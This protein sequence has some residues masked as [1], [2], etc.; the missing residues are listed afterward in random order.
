MK[1]LPLALALVLLLA[2]CS[3][4]QEGSPE[5]VEKVVSLNVTS[6]SSTRTT[7]K[8]AALSPKERLEELM[9]SKPSFKAEYEVKTVI[10]GESFEGVER[11]AFKDGDSKEET[12]N[13]S[14]YVVKGKVYTCLRE[15]EWSCL[16]VGVANET[17]DEKLPEN[18]TVTKLPSKTYAGLKGECFKVEGGEAVL[19]RCYSEQGYLL[20]FK[21]TAED[22]S[23]EMT[24]TS[25]SSKVTEE[26]F[27]L[28]AR[29]EKPGLEG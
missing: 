10:K 22:Y 7:P 8:E 14:L 24:A 6:N 17:F 11:V 2:A 20:F 4:E 15:E 18:L 9:F 3:A 29:P 26:D 25:V 28:P 19:E 13:D 27:S 23:L 1:R 12:E 5:S 21:S 16:E